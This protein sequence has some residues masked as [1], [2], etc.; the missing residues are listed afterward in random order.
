MVP[1]KSDIYTNEIF[2]I[3]KTVDCNSENVLYLINY[4]ILKV[5]NVGCTKNSNNVRFR[6]HDSHIKCV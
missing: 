5:G 3:N 1:Q 4:K 2:S 6:N